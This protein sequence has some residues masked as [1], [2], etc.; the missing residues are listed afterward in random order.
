MP[1]FTLLVAAI[2]IPQRGSTYLSKL[3]TVVPWLM[4]I[5]CQ[6]S[7]DKAVDIV[8]TVDT[9]DFKLGNYRPALRGD[10]VWLPVIF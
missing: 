9:V 3:L 8:D 2:S 7:E 6:I 4:Q 10:E 5:S 1:H